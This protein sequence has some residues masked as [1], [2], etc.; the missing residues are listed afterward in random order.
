MVFFSSKLF[1]MVKKES[2]RLMFRV[3]GKE[4]VINKFLRV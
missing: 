2:F 1:K 3:I 4:K